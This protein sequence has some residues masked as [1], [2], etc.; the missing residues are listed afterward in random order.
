MFIVI[1]ESDPFV[2][3]DLYEAMG[4][5]FTAASIECFERLEDLPDTIGHTDIAIVD[6]DYADLSQ[7]PHVAAWIERNTF[8]V[9]TKESNAAFNSD[10]PNWH[11]LERPFSE[12][13]LLNVLSARSVEDSN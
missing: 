1:I 3:I 12:Q 4:T 13:T 9:L 8:G 2:R 7:S 6:S 5:V 10:L 11:V